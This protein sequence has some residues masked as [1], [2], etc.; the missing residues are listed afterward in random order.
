MVAIV[1]VVVVRW[2]G[3]GNYMTGNEE[4]SSV[5]KN[6]RINDSEAKEKDLLFDT[7][8][9]KDIAMMRYPAGILMSSCATGC[10]EALELASRQP[11][12]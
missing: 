9:S 2:F 10:P 3:G 4:T 8:S 7:R 1:F 6:W 5:E 11:T 12:S